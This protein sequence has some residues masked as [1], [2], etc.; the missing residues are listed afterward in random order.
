M[1]PEAQAVQVGDK[2]AKPPALP[3]K[4]GYVP[5]E[6]DFRAA[7]QRAAVTLQESSKYLFHDM[8]LPDGK[9]LLAIVN[10]ISETM[11]DK[12]TA[13]AM[14][15][16]GSL[17]N[18]T[19]NNGHVA[20]AALVRPDG[21]SDLAI[22]DDKLNVR[23][24]SLTSAL[25]TSTRTF[26]TDG[27]LAA[28]SNIVKTAGDSPTI[29]YQDKL[30]FDAKGNIVHSHSETPTTTQDDARMPDGSGRQEV[31]H[32]D[33]DPKSSFSDIRVTGTDGSVVEDL[34]L[35]DGNY[36][37]LEQDSEGIKKFIQSDNAKGVINHIERQKDGTMLQFKDLMT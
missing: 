7:Q 12:P 13:T 2:Q 5:G 9:G 8:N 17:L 29:T 23:G 20:E 26:R 24:E 30:E 14:L 18:V 1:N 36:K 32:K 31:V 4:L 27:S 22:F 15:G 11:G 33:D 34:K 25:G 21:S 37:H 16:N 35:G 19:K 6:G 10:K 28:E 3:P